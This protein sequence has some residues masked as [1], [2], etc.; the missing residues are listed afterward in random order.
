MLEKIHPDRASARRFHAELLD[1]FRHEMDFRRAG[2]P[3]DA[4]DNYELIYWCA[5]LLYLVGDPAD[6]PLMWAAKQID[7]DTSCGFDGQFLVGAGIDETI[8]YLEAHGHSEPAVFVKGLKRAGD[9]D[10]LGKWQEFRIHYFYP[11]P[12][13]QKDGAGRDRKK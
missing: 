3:G 9:L 2:A 1:L 5:L 11:Q 4:E 10:E 12:T 8:D 7:F 13:S 6:A